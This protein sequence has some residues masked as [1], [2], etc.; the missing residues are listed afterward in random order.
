M[1]VDKINVSH[2][3]STTKRGGDAHIHV[4]RLSRLYYE[5]GVVVTVG[6]VLDERR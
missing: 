1:R 6:D 3:Y 2:A 4:L 5:R